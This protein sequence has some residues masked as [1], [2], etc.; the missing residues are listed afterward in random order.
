MTSKL[1]Q[2]DQLFMLT[3]PSK[4]F[5]VLLTVL[6][7]GKL[8]AAPNVYISTDTNSPITI[9][10]SVSNATSVT[11]S[12]SAQGISPTANVVST[13]LVSIVY[14]PP[15]GFNGADTFNYTVIG[16]ADAGSANVTVQ[17]G[18]LAG[19]TQT[20]VGTPNA[21]MLDHVNS[22]CT[23]DNGGAPPALVNFCSDFSIAD[24][25][26]KAVLLRELVPLE[27]GGESQLSNSVANQQIDGIRRRMATLRLGIS[28]S[29]GSLS[30]INFN[31][32][33]KNI[34]LSDWLSDDSSGGGASADSSQRYGVF[35]SG[36]AGKTT[37]Q[38]S[39]Y[40]DGY[41]SNNRGLT[42]G[43]D[44]RVTDD[45]VT[46]V[47]IGKNNSSM[48]IDQ[49]G[50]NVDVSGISLLAYSSY[51][52]TRKTY[53]EA[54]WALFKNDLDSTRALNYA[55]KQQVHSETATSQ[56]SNG[57]MSLSL[58]TGVEAL[59]YRG[60]NINVSAN[61]DYIKSAFDG[62]AESGAGDK[63]LVVDKRDSS[64]LVYNLNSQLTY[65]VSLSSGVLIPQMDFSWKHEFETE[66][67]IL[68]ARYRVDPTKTKFEF[69]TETPD[70]DYFQINLGT[71]Y[72]VPGG[73]TGFIY[74]EKTLSKRGISQYNLS[75]G[76]RIPL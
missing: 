73:N 15:S 37:H 50:G 35:V 65:P 11:T 8:V 49:S 27:L 22:I 17:V 5:L 62:Y 23:S 20:V 12:T 6:F 46:G 48:S 21:V 39:T 24:P 70:T 43:M 59:F 72:V 34:A 13:Q 76:L 45:L 32:G 64:L 74:Y 25:E 18:S 47:A 4:F 66:P 26:E 1:K 57:V 51:Y 42:A 69:R 16:G 53:V 3:W 9:N 67:M 41:M 68:K 75:L 38:E 30:S 28:G 40:E 54:I 36:K 31:L 55:I 63:N 56:T 33:G 2:L 29:G 19:G 7:A 52:V 10:I 71:S 14:N 44:Y 61:I 58:G 60:L